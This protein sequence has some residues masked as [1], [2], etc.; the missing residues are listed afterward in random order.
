MSAAPKPKGPAQGHR[1]SP[2]RLARSG[3]SGYPHWGPSY[4]YRGAVIHTDRRETYYLFELEGFPH[5]GWT[6]LGSLWAVTRLVDCWLDEGRLPPH[7]RQRGPGPAQL[8]TVPPSLRMIAMIE[9][10]GGIPSA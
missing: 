10:R 2:R 5:G 3:P 7:Y 8:P 9:G 6:G 1:D 4:A